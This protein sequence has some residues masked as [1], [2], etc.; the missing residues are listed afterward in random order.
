MGRPRWLCG[1]GLI[2]H[3][4]RV[5]R[6]EENAK[7]GPITCLS[8]TILLPCRGSGTS[9]DLGESRERSRGSG[10]GG[11]HWQER[12]PAPPLS[13]EISPPG[14]E[15]SPALGKL[16][17]SQSLQLL[18][19]PSLSACSSCRDAAGAPPRGAG[20]RSRGGH[21]ILPPPFTTALPPPASRAGTAGDDGRVGITDGFVPQ[22]LHTAGQD[23]RG[24]ATAATG[25]PSSSSP[26]LPPFPALQ[27]ALGSH[28]PAPSSPSSSSQ[29]PGAA[30]TKCGQLACGFPVGR[31]PPVPIPACV[32]LS[33]RTHL[34]Q[35]LLLMNQLFIAPYIPPQGQSLL[36]PGGSCS[37]AF[38]LLNPRCSGTPRAS[39]GLY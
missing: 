32:S 22:T 3:G 20:R 29:R 28:L 30:R 34:G 27:L 37:P 8:Q 9:W 7:F 12:G 19:A 31:S 35:A 18:L 38:S 13:P 5:G 21:P 36:K 6:C 14:M 2:L 15:V 24:Q 10:Q 39:S 11:T 23:P 4:F 33:P 16:P 26:N 17:A 25:H 1:F